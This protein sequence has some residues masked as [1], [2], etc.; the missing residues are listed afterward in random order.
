MTIKLTLKSA[1][2]K[3]LKQALMLR[4]TNGRSYTKWV[5]TGLNIDAKHWDTKQ[6]RCKKNHPA[7]L[8]INRQIAK[9]KTKRETALAKFDAGTMTLERISKFLKG[10][11]DYKSLDEYV[12]DKIKEDAQDVTFN[13][14]VTKLNVF[15]SHLG[16]KGTLEFKELDNALFKKFIKAC[17]KRKLQRASVLSYLQ[18]VT[19]ICSRALE[20]NVIFEEIKVPK[21][22]KKG[23]KN[24][25]R[26]RKPIRTV[27]SNEFLR[28]VSQIKTIQQWQSMG[29][30]LLQFGLRGLYNA[31]LVK[32]TKEEIDKPNIV[33][34]LKNEIYI[35]HLRSKSEHLD[36]HTHMRIHIDKNTTLPLLSM[37]KRSILYTTLKFHPDIIPSA[38]DE[39]KLFNYN[40]TERSKFHKNIWATQQ[41]RLKGFGMRFKDARKTFTTEAKALKINEDTRKI[42]VGRMNDPI[43][44]KAYDNNDD[45]RI[46]DAIQKAHKQ[47][48]EEYNYTS[49]V[50]ALILKLNDL[51][52]PKWIQNAYKIYLGR[53]AVGF[54]TQEKKGW[55]ST[56]KYKNINKEQDEVGV[57]LYE[58]EDVA[59]TPYYEWFSEGFAISSK[60]KKKM[61][62]ELQEYKID[63]DLYFDEQLKLNTEREKRLKPLRKYL[64]ELEIGTS[65]HLN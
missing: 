51:K 62:E 37:I 6:E 3:D 56:T 11:A 15:K 33:S 23:I 50:D 5:A 39:L 26:I 43:F 47:V 28:N 12:L 20:D 9:F 13:D 41:R 52:T 14:A 25:S 60:E 45:E 7:S 64:K 16:I 30:W 29:L 27:N 46:S 58:W 22:M 61:E 48:L 10:L 59:T 35:H 31:D 54:R 8:D 55:F 18:A 19:G 17:S 32:M 1:I 44:N 4:I 21:L 63:I 40:P 34:A 24:P 65:S 42:L 2:R 38:K 36:G 57:H 53:V 49:C